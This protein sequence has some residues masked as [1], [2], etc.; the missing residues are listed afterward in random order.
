[1]MGAA[2]RHS[3]LCAVVSACLCP[4]TQTP[5]QAP[6]Y[7]IL[8]SQRSIDA[9]RTAGRLAARSLMQQSSS[10]SQFPPLPPAPPGSI[11]LRVFYTLTLH[12]RVPA[13]QTTVPLVGLAEDCVEW[14]PATDTPMIRW[15]A[16]WR[17]VLTFRGSM[18]VIQSGSGILR[19]AW[20][21]FL[22]AHPSQWPSMPVQPRSHHDTPL[23]LL[24]PDHVLV[25]LF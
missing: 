7:L 2:C 5:V 1:M 19:R 9:G 13:N 18:A 12:I 8:D 6:A 15:R 11:A 22:C 21:W 10:P 4:C 14:G 17:H 16:S 25:L 20:V 24:G 3:L 23:V